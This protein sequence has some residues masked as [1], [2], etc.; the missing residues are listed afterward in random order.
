ME[1]LKLI[2]QST[3][4]RHQ[5][6]RAGPAASGEGAPYRYNVIEIGAFAGTPPTSSST[7]VTKRQS[8]GGTPAGGSSSSR[9]NGSSSTGGGSP[10]RVSLNE[11][12]VHED[13][14][15][16]FMKKRPV[17]V[18]APSSSSSSSTPAPT[19]QDHQKHQQQQSP[20]AQHDTGTATNSSAGLSRSASLPSSRM[21]R[22]GTS[23]TSATAA[24]SGSTASASARRNTASSGGGGARDEVEAVASLKLV[25]I[26]RA[27]AD[28]D[29]DDDLA[30]P[31]SSNTLAVSRE[32]FLRLYV[33]NMDADHCALYYLAREYDGFLEFGDSSRGVATKFLGTSDYALVWTFNRR[34][35]ETKGLFIDRCHRWQAKDTTTAAA[36]HSSI[37]TGGSVPATPVRRMGPPA[38]DSS[39]VHSTPSRKWTQA[40][41]R[42][43]AGGAVTAS[44][45]WHVF[46]DTLHM[47]RT[48][49]F[50]PQLLSFVCC[51]HMLRTYDDQAAADDLPLIRDAE[52]SIAAA[53]EA[54]LLLHHQAAAQSAAAADNHDDDGYDDGNE[55][56]NDNRDDEMMRAHHDQYRRGIGAGGGSV[57]PTQTTGSFVIAPEHNPFAPSTP[58]SEAE[59]MIHSLTSPSLPP[60]PAAPPTTTTTRTTTTA[61]AATA[62]AA[63]AERHRL[64][65]HAL[66]GSRAGTSLAD[67]LRHLQTA[68]A[69]LGA[70]SREH[71]TVVVD[72][73]AAEF[74]DRYHRSM[75]GMT[76]AVPALERHV[77]SLEEYLR[78]LKGRA[79]RLGGGGGGTLVRYYLHLLGSCAGAAASAGRPAPPPAP[80]PASHHDH[81]HHHPHHHRHATSS[82]RATQS[83]SL[84]LR[85]NEADSRSGRGSGYGGTATTA[86]ATTTRTTAATAWRS[87]RGGGGAPTG[88]GISAAFAALAARGQQ[89]GPRPRSRDDGAEREGR[90]RQQP[91][92][93][94]GASSSRRGT[95]GGEQRRGEGGADSRGRD[96]GFYAG[97]LL[98]GNYSHRLA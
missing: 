66:A 8:Y 70:L 94:P 20:D 27:Q 87:D 36:V 35:L 39:S 54:A 46:R 69:A 33:D 31:D 98:R 44:A 59:K 15:G 21:T 4:D 2:A 96:L 55:N 63:A 79:E 64:L 51:V 12:M 89:Q 19:Q 52:A 30:G 10:S 47:Y 6:F 75:E 91:W 71:E 29:G 95:H 1:G 11:W 43:G 5:K 28:L 37:P 68:R 26:Q 85:C 3:F 60:P 67:K 74:L 80:P 81:H 88:L 9:Q 77:A 82:S 56:D 13:D 24:T 25:C 38:G 92:G 58:P 86:A 7:T 45:A 42:S 97:Y 40:S 78:Y 18:S 61:K 73:V 48:Y 93:P 90:E 50:A 83:D 17:H 23:N 53:H 41:S 65:S 32:T 84:S 16:A 76:E 34:T 72:V 22:S 57:L 49:V 62:A 14:L